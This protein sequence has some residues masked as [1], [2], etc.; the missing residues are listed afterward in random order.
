MY[1]IIVA[2]AVVAQS[3]E[4]FLGKEEV[5]S[6]NLLNSSKIKT[7]RLIETLRFLFFISA[8]NKPLDRAA[9]GIHRVKVLLCDNVFSLSAAHFWGRNCPKI[10]VSIK[11]WNRKFWPRPFVSTVRLF[12]SK[13]WLCTLKYQ[14]FLSAKLQIFFRYTEF[15]FTDFGRCSACRFRPPGLMSII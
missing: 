9:F 5:G 6:S 14:I 15:V 4:H 11:K 3:V 8:S 1:T 12:V 2:N 7:S 10:S 13:V